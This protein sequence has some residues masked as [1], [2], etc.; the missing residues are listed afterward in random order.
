MQCEN[1]AAQ[2]SVERGFKE[3]DGAL[4]MTFKQLRQ[5]LD[6]VLKEDYSTFLGEQNK[7]NGSYDRVRTGDVALLLEKFVF[8]RARAHAQKLF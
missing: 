4:S 2:S 6:L 3:E 8:A 7:P 5:L 1:F